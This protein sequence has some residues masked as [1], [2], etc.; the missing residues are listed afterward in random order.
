MGHGYKQRQELRRFQL[1]REVSVEDGG[2]PIEIVVDFLMPRHAEIVKNDPPIISDFAVQRADGAD[3]AMRFCQLVAIS[4]NMP[5][6]GI[7][8]VEIAVCSIPALHAVPPRQLR[9]RRVLA[10]CLQCNL[11]LERRIK[12]LA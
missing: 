12:L 5:G 7:N 9:D 11:R 1:A 4:G 10:Q 3:L 2:H 8:S 6:G